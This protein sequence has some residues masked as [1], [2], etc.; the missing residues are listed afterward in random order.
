[1][2]GVNQALSPL[3]VDFSPYRIK[4]FVL[5]CKDFG[6]V[7]FDGFIDDCLDGRRSPRL[8]F[9]ISENKGRFR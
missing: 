5:F 4:Q 8:G 7:P 9:D 3:A 1:M 6:A 2:P